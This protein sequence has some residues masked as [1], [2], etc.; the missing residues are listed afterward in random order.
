MEPHDADE[1]FQQ[2]RTMTRLF[3]AVYGDVTGEE[4]DVDGVLRHGPLLAIG[5]AAGVGGLVGWWWGRRERPALPPAKSDSVWADLPLD[6]HEGIFPGV[7]QQ[8]RDALPEITVSPAIRHAGAGWL[9]T[10]LEARLD[11]PTGPTEQP[12][13]GGLGALLRQVNRQLSSGEDTRLVDP[14]EEAGF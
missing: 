5:V 13:P 9:R 10:V 11:P 12:A 7:A 2:I 3:I 4:F 14:E 8:L 6:R 1:S